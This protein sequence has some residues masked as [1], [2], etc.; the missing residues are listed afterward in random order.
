[1]IKASIST[2]KVILYFQQYI[3]FQ[4]NSTLF[5]HFTVHLNTMDR[6]RKHS[7]LNSTCNKVWLAYATKLKPNNV[8][9]SF[10][11]VKWFGSILIRINSIDLIMER[12]S[13][14]NSP[15]I[16]KEHLS[17][18]TESFVVLK[19]KICWHRFCNRAHCHC[20]QYRHENRPR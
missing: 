2:L 4:Y 20:R 18:V 6:A 15:F 5:N 7:L 19:I 13:R 12:C 14:E 8:S 3:C 16:S 17:S 10:E 9:Q 11:M 1:M